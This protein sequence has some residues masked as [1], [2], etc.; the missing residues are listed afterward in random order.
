MMQPVDE[1]QFE[2]YAEY[3]L[4]NGVQR[5]TGI[6]FQAMAKTFLFYS[7]RL[8]RLWFPLSLLSNGYRELCPPRVKEPGREADHSP[9]SIAEV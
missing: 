9:K 4:R 2:L 8:D 1:D 3:R 6:L 5:G 7:Q